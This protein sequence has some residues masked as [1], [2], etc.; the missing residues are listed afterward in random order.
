MQLRADALEGW[1][2]AHA[3]KLPPAAWVHGDEPLLRIE[4]ADAIRAAYRRAGCAEREVFHADR[5]FRVEQLA[6]EANA[7]SLFATERLL[8]LRLAAKPGK[9]LGESLASIAGSLADGVRLLVTGPRLDRA[10]TESAWFREIERHAI[11]VPVYP[12]EPAQLTA[13]IGQRLARQQQRADRDTLAFLAERVEGNLLAA[14]QEIRKLGL[15]FPAGALPDDAVRAAVLNVARYDAR[16]AADAMLSGDVART[17]RAIEGLRAEGEAEPLVLWALADAVR[18]LLR[19][20]LATAAGRAPGQVLREL[21]VYPPRDRLYERALARLDRGR[22]EQAL[23]RAA[24]TDR[25][26]KGVA[27]GDAWSSI[28]AL[29]LTVAG[30]DLPADPEFAEP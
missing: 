7:M 30:A 27:P 22:L 20:R 16:D 14:Q 8:E 5:G 1:L 4:A 24:R 26:I 28:Q 23:H 18:T 10:A 19:A 17:L 29:A 6:A 13:W 25:M 21:R 15:L 11:V 12:V 3:A 9:E 2:A